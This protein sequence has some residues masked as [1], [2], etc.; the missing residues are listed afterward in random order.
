[1]ERIG[2][3]VGIGY[4]SQQAQRT[5]A[6][7]GTQRW[8]R[9]VSRRRAAKRAS[10][11]A[12]A[13]PTAADRLRRARCRWRSLSRARSRSRWPHG[14]AINIADSASLDRREAA[15]GQ[16]RLLR[17]APVVVAL[18]LG[19]VGVVNAQHGILQ[20]IRN[21]RG[22]SDGPSARM[23][24]CVSRLSAAAPV[25]PMINPPIMTSSLISTKPRVL[26]LTTRESL[27]G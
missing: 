1:M 17:V 16:L 11:E 23:I 12:I 6:L 22:I 8:L 5:A 27:L 15:R 24:N 14:R 7:V 2:G 19:A 4:N 25:W 13:A 3:T 9:R 20:R 21:T 18:D 26:M 10:P